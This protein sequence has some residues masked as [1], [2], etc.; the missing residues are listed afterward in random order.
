VMMN[1]WRKPPKKLKSRDH[2][3]GKNSRCGSYLWGVSMQRHG[4]IACTRSTG[5]IRRWNKEEIGL[6]SWEGFKCEQGGRAQEQKCIVEE[7]CI[8]G[9]WCREYKRQKNRKCKG[10][11]EDID[12][13]RE[14]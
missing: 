4:N 10:R 9:I 7:G 2:D 12:A 11:A 3:E 14:E 6:L 1:A 13:D 5:T 8:E